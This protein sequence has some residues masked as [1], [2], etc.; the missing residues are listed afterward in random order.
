MIIYKVDYQTYLK[1]LNLED[2]PVK[3]FRVN[4]L[5]P[6]TMVFDKDEILKGVSSKYVYG[7]T[8]S[9]EY[10]FVQRSKSVS[11]GDTYNEMY[12]KIKKLYE[13]LVDETG[14]YQLSSYNEDA[15]GLLSENQY[16]ATDEDNNLIITRSRT[17]DEDNFPIQIHPEINII[18][19]KLT[20][21]A[22]KKHQTE[23]LFRKLGI[24]GV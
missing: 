14:Y 7:H 10:S 20:E 17:S 4:N 19:E 12:H 3:E 16:I 18:L 11:F 2:E 6:L 5:Y 23:L 22:I 1:I 24:D 21:D 13:Y 15:Y 9:R 8:S